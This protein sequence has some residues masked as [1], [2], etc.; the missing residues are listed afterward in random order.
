MSYLPV[1][2]SFF[3]S[4]D[5]PGDELPPWVN[6]SASPPSDSD[7]LPAPVNPSMSPPSPS[8]VNDASIPGDQSGGEDADGVAPA[9]K[10][11]NDSGKIVHLLV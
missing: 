10:D 5:L 3:D 4:P 9:N 8:E 2:T 11:D 6:P 7:Q 1:A